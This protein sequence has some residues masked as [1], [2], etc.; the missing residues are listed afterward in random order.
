LLPTPSAKKN[1]KTAWKK[2]RRKSPSPRKL[3]FAPA[4]LSSR[5]YSNRLS[6]Q[7]FNGGASASAPETTAKAA[8]CIP[9]KQANRSPLSP[10]FPRNW[11][12]GYPYLATRYKKFPGFPPFLG[13]IALK[14]IVARSRL[15][16][17]AQ[18]A[19]KEKAPKS[20]EIGVFSCNRQSL[21]DL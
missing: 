18:A 8:A 2:G 15:C 21:K 7:I 11:G 14:I 12:C 10:T 19:I 13:K 5:F 1:H 6:L 4:A 20:W 17:L 9:Q 16:K 3:A